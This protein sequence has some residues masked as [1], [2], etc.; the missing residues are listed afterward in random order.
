MW[1]G[2]FIYWNKMKVAIQGYEG[3][4]HDIV[5]K[6]FFSNN[7][8]TI[9]CNTFELF[10]E[11]IKAEN[12]QY[13]VMAIENS[14]VGTIIHNYNLLKNSDYTITGEAYLEIQHH[15]MAL[16]DQTLND[17]K[18]VKSHEM[19]ILQCSNYFKDKP[20]IKLEKGFDTALV[21]KEIKKD[22]IK[23]LAAIASK[24]AAALNGLN[25]LAKGIQNYSKNYT[26]FLVLAKKNNKDYHYKNNNKVSIYFS[27]EHRPGSLAQV[28]STFSYF[29]LN[30]TKIESVPKV[31]EIWQYYFYVDIEYGDTVSILECMEAIKHYT[32]NMEILGV[33]KKGNTLLK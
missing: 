10:F 3:S 24:P 28:L 9:E 19:A 30:L 8:D 16:K 1:S 27:L 33:Y 18:V 32:S 17:I 14:I 7:I 15:L 26:R 21:A 23:G 12:I 20:W 6:E 5:A 4:F 25:I 2:F 31:T 13:G 29:G 22:Q 11:T